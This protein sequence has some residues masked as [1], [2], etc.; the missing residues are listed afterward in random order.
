M[1]ADLHERARRLAIM[2]LVE[3][4]PAADRDSLEAHLAECPACREH[5]RSLERVIGGLR[6]LSATAGE[7]L[8]RATQLRVRRRAAEL[9][10]RQAAMRPFWIACAMV[11][12]SSL[13][14]TPALWQ[15]FAWIGNAVQ[16]STP[17]LRAAFFVFWISP[18]LAA[19]ALLLG[20]GS[21]LGRW[22]GSEFSR[23]G[24]A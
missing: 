14:L 20:C 3:D 21:H 6:A 16:L 18:A 19:S 8:V 12:A 24:E 10:L 4:A 2:W 9:R 23:S 22:R 13:V 11:A 5:N 1:S 17:I 7:P 15:V